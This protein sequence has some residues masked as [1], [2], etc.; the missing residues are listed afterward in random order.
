[1]KSA[2]LLI[3]LLILALGATSF[4]F[5]RFAHE[6]KDPTGTSKKIEIDILKGMRPHEISFALEKEG[7]VKSGTLFYWLGRFTGGWSGL[8]AADYELN[9]SMTPLQLF[10]IFKSG[11]GI[12]RSIL[13]REGNT[14]FQIAE[15]F[16][17]EGL[18]T[19][20]KILSYLRSPE[21]ILAFGLKD[22]AIQSFEGYLY[23][24]TYFFD[25]RETATNLIKRMVD[26]F[27][28]TWTPEFDTRAKEIG[29]TRKQVVILASMVE[30]ETGA[31][32][33]RPVIASVF[34]N[35]MKKK[36]KFQSDPT[37][38]YGMGESFSGNLR[39]DDLKRP[40]AYNTYTLPGLPIGPISNPNPESV[41]A[42][43]YPA[44]TDYLYFVSK[45]D[46][47]HMFSKTYGEHSDW[48]RKLQLD[49]KARAG[50]SWRD[51]SKQGKIKPEGA[52][53]Q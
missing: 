25:R 1:M 45:N 32:F 24:N 46:G 6:A 20:E 5:Y 13:I 39:R 21:L 15:A 22:E 50:K 2:K 18:G 41:R 19:R 51:L 4:I 10:K 48:V 34:F 8:R 43:L 28:H 23:P 37:T 16:E 36:M 35:R 17:K 31:S 7:I 42:V 3:F 40:S 47:T 9:A 29:L 26:A 53:S 38:A 12:Q 52:V 30:R 27:L 11:I 33:E 14:I 49:P 44:D